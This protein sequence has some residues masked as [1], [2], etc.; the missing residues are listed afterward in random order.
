MCRYVD[1][2]FASLS[3]K[4]VARADGVH[5]RNRVN[6]VRDNPAACWPQKLS[7]RRWIPDALVYWSRSILF[8]LSDR[9]TLVPANQIQSPAVRKVKCT[10][11]STYI[12]Y[13]PWNKILLR[14]RR[15][16]DRSLRI[17]VPSLFPN[18]SATGGCLDTHTRKVPAA[19]D[20]KGRHRTNLFLCRHSVPVWSQVRRKQSSFH[21]LFPVFWNDSPSPPD[22]TVRDRANALS[23][24]L[25]FHHRSV[26]PPQD[27]PLP[28]RRMKSK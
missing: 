9:D 14:N 26:R 6:R 11:V 1:T 21:I 23:S 24:L 4:H 15:K 19:K 5:S 12:P 2:L 10:S 13:P 17:C 16:R 7:D 22:W 8:S 18:L 28:G 27:T 20:W 3:R 25:S